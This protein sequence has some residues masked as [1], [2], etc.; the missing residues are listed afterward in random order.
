M[1]GA[2]FDDYVDEL[3]GWPESDIAGLLRTLA[4]RIPAEHE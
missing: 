4:R 1:S 2:E 3:M